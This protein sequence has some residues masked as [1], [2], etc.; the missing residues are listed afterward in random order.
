[1]I[2]VYFSRKLVITN[3]MM[4]TF[5]CDTKCTNTD[6]VWLKTV[7]VCGVPTLLDKNDPEGMFV[8]VIYFS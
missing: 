5:E 7:K 8:F 1:M 4:G 2:L 3:N 6:W